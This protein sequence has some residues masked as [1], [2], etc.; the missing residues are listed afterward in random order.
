VPRH[1]WLEEVLKNGPNKAQCLVTRINRFFGNDWAAVPER[2]PE[3]ED[4]RFANLFI[5][6]TDSKSSRLQLSKL[7]E[8]HRPGNGY[9][10]YSTPLYWC[11]FG[12]A[13]KTGQV[14]M[15]TIRRN[16]KQP[17][18][19]KFETVQ[20]LPFVT[21]YV[22]GYA[23]IREEESG[24]SCSISGGARQTG[25]VRQL[26]AGASGVQSAVEDV[27]RGRRLLSRILH[28]SRYDARQSDRR[29]NLLSNDI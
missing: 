22:K 2:Y 11:D 3:P 8:A 24:P 25:S 4:N 12:N 7:L 16:I 20:R 13:Q 29:M 1:T 15:G 18:S 17:K 5:T 10:D 28:E 9:T 27:P 21:E 19:E 14:I 26:H 23:R 6:C